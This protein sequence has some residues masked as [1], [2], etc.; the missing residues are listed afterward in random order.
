MDEG[1][2]V[3]FIPLRAADTAGVRVLPAAAI[4]RGTR[5]EEMTELGLLAQA[6]AVAFT[7]GEKT[8]TSSRLMRRAL[9]Y[10]T[11]FDLLLMQH[12]EDASLAKGGV[13]NEGEV[14]SSE[15]RRVGKECVR[16]CRSR[17]SPYH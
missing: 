17:W 11:T 3:E 10:A 12:C 8:V 13:M 7:E 5:G 9:S 6:G 15:E 4:T 14:A 1:A 16:T 2:L